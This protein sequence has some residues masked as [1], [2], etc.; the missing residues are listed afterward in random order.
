MSA[1]GSIAST[2]AER[3]QMLLLQQS[4]SAASTSAAASTQTDTAASSSDG[5][6]NELGMAALKKMIEEAIRAALA[7]L[8][9]S[10]SAQE[11]MS[12]VKNAVDSTLEANGIQ[13]G[14]PP[15]GSG[16]PMDGQAPAD[17]QAA[18]GQAPPSG[19]PPAGGPPPG[20]QG[21]LGSTI[22]SLLEEA[23]FDPD[24][25]RSEL[26]NPTSSSGT[27]TSNSAATLSLILQ[28]PL[29]GGIDT[30]V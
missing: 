18:A 6:S 30:Q 23:G 16:P 2:S 7:S 11:V 3:L 17:G 9:S 22:D 1:V 25:I 28:I 15:S 5:T 20:G 26:M 29:N 27:S 10:S 19:P 4:L 24:K 12:A 13:P 8:E 14:P 21:D